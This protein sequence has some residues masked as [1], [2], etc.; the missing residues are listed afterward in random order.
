M[1]TMTTTTEA[2]A[3]QFAQRASAVGREH[4]AWLRDIR[5]EAFARFEDRG[6]PTVHDEAWH[7]TNP[8]PLANTEFHLSDLDVTQVSPEQISR[9]RLGGGNEAL[10]VFVNGRFAWHLSDL[11]TLPEGVRVTSL[12]QALAAELPVVRHHL[13]RYAGY[14]DNAFVALNTAFAEEGAFVEIPRGAVV[15]TPIHL[16][17]VSCANQRPGVAHPRILILAGENSQFRVIEHYV[18]LGEGVY[19]NNPVTELVA[20]ENVVGDHCKVV[21]ESERAYHVATL[22]I[23]QARGSNIASQTICLGGVLVRNDINPVLNGEGAFCNLDGLYMLDGKQHADNHL[24]VDHRSPHTS[25]REFFRGLLGGNSRG[26]FCGR[27]IVRPGAQKTD[28]K[29]TN[30]NLLLSE[31]AEV[32]TKPQLE[33]LADDVK[34]THGA[35]IGQINPDAVFYLRSRGIDEESAR[36]L[37]V[38]AFAR[39]SLASVQD[40]RLRAQLE[41]LVLSRLPNGELLRGLA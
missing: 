5:E 39:E 23:H 14:K 11:T 24:R 29:Q 40:P 31:R 27:I 41:Q 33:I 37:L 1:S 21:R 25:S 2:Y 9:F 15:E 32:D 17:F 20:G 34:C 10:L 3:E 22:Q 38:Y 4:P 35:T 28:A 19:F 16:L 18:P 12:S 8:Q 26:V 6:F 36:S 30:M 7:Y 13:T